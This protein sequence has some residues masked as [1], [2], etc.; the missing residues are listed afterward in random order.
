MET[1]INRISIVHQNDTKKLMQ[2]ISFSYMI[3][4]IKRA[5]CECCEL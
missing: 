1:N 2:I 5:R 4:M 3:N